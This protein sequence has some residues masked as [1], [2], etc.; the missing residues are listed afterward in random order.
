MDF[1]VGAPGTSLGQ[2]AQPYQN[3]K[4]GGMDWQPQNTAQ[5]ASDPRLQQEMKRQQQAF[6][7]ARVSMPAGQQFQ[8]P[9]GAVGVPTG[10]PRQGFMQP[11]GGPTDQ[12]IYNQGPAPIGDD[13]F[14]PVGRLPGYAPQ[15][16]PPPPPQ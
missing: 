14:G 11:I 12:S 1:S 10:P 8:P 6:N 13:T 2:P 15:P 5:P 16:S 3:L 4:M 9:R 7:D